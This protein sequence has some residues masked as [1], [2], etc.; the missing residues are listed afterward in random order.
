[1]NKDKDK[2]K[3]HEQK[4]EDSFHL[5]IYSKPMALKSQGLL[6]ELNDNKGTSKI[7]LDPE[8]EIEDYIVKKEAIIRIITKTHELKL[9]KME[10]QLNELIAKKGTLTDVEKYIHVTINKKEYKLNFATNL[11]ESQVKYYISFINAIF[12]II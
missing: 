2:Y 8:I 4:T 10:K 11:S 6:I 3:N 12:K 5:K 9:E 1:M 7:G